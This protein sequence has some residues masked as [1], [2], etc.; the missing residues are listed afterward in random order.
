MP[1]F[2]LPSGADIFEVWGH[3]VF[4]RDK[5]MA[6]LYALS[7]FIDF[8]GQQPSIIDA[9]VK[10]RLAIDSVLKES[11]NDSADLRKDVEKQYDL[12]WSD[13]RRYL[14]AHGGF[15]ALVKLTSSDEFRRA[16]RKAIDDGAMAGKMLYR[17]I[18]L[19]KSGIKASKEKACIIITGESSKKKGYWVQGRRLKITKDPLYKCWK[20]HS[21]VSHW[22][23][24]YWHLMLHVG[25][26]SPP[27]QL[28]PHA[29]QGL[30]VF[31]AVA[32]WLLSVA[33]EIRVPSQS[34]KEK[35]PPLDSKTAYALPPGF[36]RAEITTDIA[37]LEEWAVDMLASEYK[38]VRNKLRKN[39]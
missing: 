26:Q 14:D 36:P 6:E 1:I 21:L 31:A 27:P 22:W 18:Q 13:F 39:S 29:P 37:P 19:D 30:P 33:G 15:E 35:R 32:D 5:Q 20:N 8:C 17:I 3:I 12:I 10:D 4:P 24:A 7:C 28:N 38:S 25:R 2:A 34:G 23:A 16:K 11:K 9:Y